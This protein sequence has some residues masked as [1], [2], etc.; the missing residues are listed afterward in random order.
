M[1]FISSELNAYIAKKMICAHFLSLI[2][3]KK[4]CKYGNSFCGISWWKLLE[5]L[6]DC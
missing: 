4:H 3:H 5:P 6:Y 1:I 2:P